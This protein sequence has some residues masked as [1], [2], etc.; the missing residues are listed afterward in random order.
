MA[1][2]AKYL[3]IDISNAKE[4]LDKLRAVHTEENF[5][6]AVYRAFKRT[7]NYT[8]KIVA[9]DVSEHYNITQKRV[10]EHI[11]APRTSMGTG[12]MGVSCVIPITGRRLTVGGTYN[13][14][15]GRHGWKGI[16]AGKRYKITAKIVRNEQSTLPEEMKRQGGQPPF[17]NLSAPKL[18][19]IAFTR[20][21]KARDA[22]IVPVVGLAVPQMPMNRAREDV[23]AD[24]VDYLK[25]RLEHEHEYLVSKCR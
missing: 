13:A 11:G 17:R 22:K 21:G 8:K 25:K 19:K 6:K 4:T 7:G 24:V 9:K 18:K 23:Q 14:K 3:D 10:R 1:K 15:G 16:K 5:K 2:N 12:A 20:I